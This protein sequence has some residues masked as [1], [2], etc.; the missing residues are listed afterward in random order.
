MKNVNNKPKVVKEDK[1]K[2]KRVAWNKGL[3]A[4]WAKNNPQTFKKGQ[5]GARTGIKASKE[6]K[7]KLSKSHR[8]VQAGNKHPNWKGGKYD[9][10][11]RNAPR[12]KP[13]TCEACGSNGTICYDHDHITDKF[14]GWLCMKCNFALGHV[15]DDKK[16]LLDLIN[17]LE[18]HEKEQ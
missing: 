6:L 11:K 4:P 5:V 15:N 16:I 2:I 17:Y 18:K 1:V 10:N 9:Y 8:G 7:E 3:P 14:R 13:D 12:P